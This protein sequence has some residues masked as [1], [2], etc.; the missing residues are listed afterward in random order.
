MNEYEHP[1]EKVI[2]HLEKQCMNGWYF[3]KTWALMTSGV[4]LFLGLI[5]FFAL[6]KVELP[7]VCRDTV[8]AVGIVGFAFAVFNAGASLEVYAEQKKNFKK[9]MHNVVRRRFLKGV[10][11][12]PRINIYGNAN[13]VRLCSHCDRDYTDPP[14]ILHLDGAS[15]HHYYQVMCPK[16]WQHTAWYDT[17]N[18][19]EEAWNKK[20]RWLLEGSWEKD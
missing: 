6:R 1:D 13:V 2:R 5:L 8:T 10:D 11:D 20:Y 7:R 16:C 12:N 3:G 17:P 9:R 14:E 4:L 15:G 19:A 18:E